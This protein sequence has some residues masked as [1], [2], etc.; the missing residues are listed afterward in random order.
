MD[1]PSCVY[2]YLT[3]FSSWA[4]IVACYYIYKFHCQPH[5]RTNW[6]VF[7]LGSLPNIHF[8]FR[9]VFEYL[10]FDTQ[11]VCKF[12]F[13]Y[14]IDRLWAWAFPLWHSTLGG[15]RAQKPT[16]L[17]SLFDLDLFIDW[18]RSK[19]EFSH[20]NI[21]SSN[22]KI[23]FLHRENFIRSTN[24]HLLSKSGLQIVLVFQKVKAGVPLIREVFWSFSCLPVDNYR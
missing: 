11:G 16:W 23:L 2:F 13:F 10:Y 1:R 14:R 8:H 18:D 20:S 17:I 4:H 9:N 6:Y 19:M 3:W 24:F 7:E 5:F 12:I 22:M 21:M 15:D